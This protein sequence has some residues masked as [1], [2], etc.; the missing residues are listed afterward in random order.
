[1]NKI[2]YFILVILFCGALL[3]SLEKSEYHKVLQTDSPYEIY[4]DFNDNQTA[5]KDELVA[6]PSKNFQYKN[7]STSDALRMYYLADNYAKTALQN[8]FVKVVQKD[9]GVSIIDNNL[10]DYYTNLEK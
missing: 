10:K 9:T 1:M 3:F 5:E 7:L 8:K 4:V 6:L 2:A